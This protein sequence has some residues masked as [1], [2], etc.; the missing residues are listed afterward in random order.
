MSQGFGGHRECPLAGLAF[1]GNTRRAPSLESG[2][3]EPAGEAQKAWDRQC[4]PGGGPGERAVV[5]TAW[6]P[7]TVPPISVHLQL[8]TQR[9]DPTPDHG[10]FLL[11]PRHAGRTE[12]PCPSSP[13]TAHQTSPHPHEEGEL[14]P[15]AE[16]SPPPSLACWGGGLSGLPGAASRPASQLPSS[17]LE[18]ELRALQS[19]GAGA[20]RSPA[21]QVW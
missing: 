20:P 19:S 6:W 21:W 18:A 17:P 2:R 12:Q 8:P 10:T 16:P 11:H 13:K 1:P 7:L 14:A 9:A 15:S 3:K 5:G 4:Q